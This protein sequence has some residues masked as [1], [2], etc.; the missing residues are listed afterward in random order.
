LRKEKEKEK[1]K[2]VN[3]V[4]TKKEG[5]SQRPNKILVAEAQKAEVPLKEKKKKSEVGTGWKGEGRHQGT[6]WTT[7]SLANMGGADQ[8]KEER[9]RRKRELSDPNSVQPRAQKKKRGKRKRGAFSRLQDRTRRLNAN[10]AKGRVPLITRTCTEND[11]I[12]PAPGADKKK[13]YEQQPLELQGK[14]TG[15]PDRKEA[16]EGREKLRII[17]L[18]KRKEKAAS[19]HRGETRGGVREKKRVFPS[20][21]KKGRT[22]SCVGKKDEARPPEG[23]KRGAGRAWIPPEGKGNEVATGPSSAAEGWKDP[24]EERGGT[25]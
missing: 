3:A 16:K 21:R 7:A 2:E 25:T 1:A 11:G 20:P 5:G 6:P 13:N 12:P 4:A 8:Q 19:P 23:K 15:R 10:K 9:K 18:R 22:G 14:R 17:L 24:G